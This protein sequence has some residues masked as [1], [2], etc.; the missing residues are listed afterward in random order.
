MVHLMD[1]RI[2]LL[3]ILAFIWA[4]RS[5]AALRALHTAPVI[6]PE[7]RRPAKVH[8]KVSVIIPAKNEEKNIG[9]CIQRFLLQDYP[10]FEIIVANDNSRD[11]TEEILKSFGTK[12]RYVNV[13]PTPQGWT[14]KNFAVHSAL[15]LATGDWYLFTDADT[16]HHKSSISAAMSHADSRNLAFLTLLPE[17]LTS[18]LIEKI[19]QPTMMGF[20]G[21]WF[22]LNRIND[23]N[24]K[25]YF[26]NGQYML[27]E[28]DL[29]HRIGGHAAVHDQFLE[30]FALMKQAKDMGEKVECALGMDVYGTRMYESFKSLWR[31]W[32]RIFLHAF[33]RK[34]SVLLGK[35]FDVFFTSVFPFLIPFIF[36][37]TYLKNPSEQAFF[38]I[39]TVL[40]LAFILTVV[41][42]T[43]SIIRSRRRFFLFFPLAAS[44][45][46]LIMINATWLAMTGSKTKWR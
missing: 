16:R 31:G 38:G 42:K 28:A 41:W 35:T 39:F 1:I 12:I 23:P 40:V 26:A 36:I 11:K 43:Y 18:G 5:Q 46:M 2:L 45:L 30:D 6:D 14:G 4:R 25:F 27:M 34:V 17:C 22:P 15:S 29:H 44:T 7:F 24:S 13:S 20:V 10:N 19:F 37:P 33:Q 32:R 21:L 3:L 9:D 8:P